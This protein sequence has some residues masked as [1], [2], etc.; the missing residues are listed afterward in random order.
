MSQQHHTRWKELAAKFALDP[1]RCWPPATLVRHADFNM[2][3]PRWAPAHS[4]D[5]KLPIVAA[6]DLYIGACE[7]PPNVLEVAVNDVLRSIH[8]HE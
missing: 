8:W 7:A 2:V 1:S 6:P 4:D 3:A 5:V